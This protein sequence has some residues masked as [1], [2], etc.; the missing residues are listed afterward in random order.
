[1]NTNAVT[2]ISMSASI[3]I[4]CVE[5][6]DG[7]TILETVGNIVGSMVGA[8][9]LLIGLYVGSMVGSNVGSSVGSLV[10]DSVVDI[11]KS[12]SGFN[13]VMHLTMLL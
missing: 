4:P 13:S 5:V 6:V 10:G 2:D 7:I 12:G 3:T 8:T 1:M 11:E 9:P